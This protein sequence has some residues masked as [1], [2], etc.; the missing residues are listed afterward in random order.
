V[1][2]AAESLLRAPEN[3]EHGR[4]V[5]LAQAERKGTRRG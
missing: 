1:L 2:V 4:H 3:L 5:V